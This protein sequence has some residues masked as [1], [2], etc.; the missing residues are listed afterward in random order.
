MDIKFEKRYSDLSNEFEQGLGRM[1]TDEEKAFLKWVV[2]QEC[3]EQKF[4][5]PNMKL[6]VLLLHR[7]GFPW[8]KGKVLENTKNRRIEPK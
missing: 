5:V 4:V 2:R 3:E 1:L 7:K 8:L 6:D